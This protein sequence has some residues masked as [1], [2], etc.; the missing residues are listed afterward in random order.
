MPGGV[1]RHHLVGPAAQRSLGGP[2]LLPPPGEQRP[3]QGEQLRARGRRGRRPTGGA[4]RPAELRG[5]PA[6]L[7]GGS[8][9]HIALCNAFALRVPFS[10]KKADRA[11]ELALA[12]WNKKTPNQKQGWFNERRA[13]QKLIN[14]RHLREELDNEVK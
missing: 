3:E 10:R 11:I 1:G 14:E 5:E 13:T 9:V 7:F 6:Q 12:E 8:A 2:D 4:H